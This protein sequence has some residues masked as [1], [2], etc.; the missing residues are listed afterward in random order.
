MADFDLVHVPA[1][2]I[3]WQIWTDTNVPSRLNPVTGLPHRYLTVQDTVTIEF[4][5]IVGGVQAPADAALGGRLFTWAWVDFF[6]RGLA[7]PPPI[8]SPVGFGFSSKATVDLTG[9]PRG[10]YVIQALRPTGGSIL[11]PFESIAT[12]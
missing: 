7:S 8:V 9:H 4:N 6:N 1:A 10:H 3:A 5:T 11:F 12:L 2:K